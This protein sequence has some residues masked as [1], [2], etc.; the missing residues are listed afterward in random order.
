MHQEGNVPLISKVNAVRLSLI[1]DKLMKQKL[2]HKQIS[3]QRQT[4][5]VSRQKADSGVKTFS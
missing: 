3:Y 5:T 2:L 4:N 1:F